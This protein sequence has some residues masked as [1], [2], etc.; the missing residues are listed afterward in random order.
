[1]WLVKTTNIVIP[2]P[3]PFDQERGHSIKFVATHSFAKLSPN[4]NFWWVE[5]VFNLWPHPAGKTSD[6]QEKAIYA[7]QKLS[8]FKSSAQEG[9][10]YKLPDA[11]GER[12]YLINGFGHKIICVDEECYRNF[13]ESGKSLNMMLFHL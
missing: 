12:W 11:R 5:L 2:S 3:N 13:I 4:S 6:K 7:K 10:K 1:M 8:V 9:S